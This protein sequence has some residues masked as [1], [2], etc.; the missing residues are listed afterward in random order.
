MNTASIQNTNTPQ[1]QLTT[2]T[3]ADYKPGGDL[4]GVQ[5]L[6]RAITFNIERERSCQ[7]AYIH[8]EKSVQPY[9]SGHCVAYL[10]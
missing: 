2:L 5:L 4:I 10:Q 8:H 9:Q 1:E 3:G 7:N 6:E